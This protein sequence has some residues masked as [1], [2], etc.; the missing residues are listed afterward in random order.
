MNILIYYFSITINIKSVSQLGVSEP[1]AR[2]NSGL[3]LYLS[4]ALV[5]CLLATDFNKRTVKN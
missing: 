3:L 1:N 2:K 4:N 5:E